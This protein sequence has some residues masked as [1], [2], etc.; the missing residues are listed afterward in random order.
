MLGVSFGEVL[1]IAVVALLLF[2]PERLPEV[3]RSAGRLLAKVNHA[4]DAVQREIEQSMKEGAAAEDSDQSSPSGESR[5]V[6]E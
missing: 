4:M 2:G 3:A 5:G 6:H 1:V